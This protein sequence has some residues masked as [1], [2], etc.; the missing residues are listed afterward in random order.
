MLSSSVITGAA[1]RL[2]GF[3]LL[4]ILNELWAYWIP[5]PPTGWHWSPLTLS[6]HRA[7]T[8]VV[9]LFLNSNFLSAAASYSLNSGLNLWRN[10][11]QK[12]WRDRRAGAGGRSE[13]Q[14]GSEAAVGRRRRT[15]VRRWSKRER[16][17]R[18]QGRRGRCN[19]LSGVRVCVTEEE[20]H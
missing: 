6:A 12:T 11:H 9:F 8:A 17:I 13:R 1:V 10:P 19:Y 15:G 3:E 18:K 16:Q 14:R 4:V 20:A 7:L 2:M 5:A